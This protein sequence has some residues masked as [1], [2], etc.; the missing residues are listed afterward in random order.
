MALVDGTLYTF[1]V[2]IFMR[3]GEK[4]LGVCIITNFIEILRGKKNDILTYANKL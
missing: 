2:W 4:S 1:K 3:G